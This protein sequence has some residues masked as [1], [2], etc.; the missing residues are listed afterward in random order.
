MTWFNNRKLL[1]ASQHQ[2][3]KAIAPLMEQAFSLF[4]E[5]PRQFDSDVFGT[6]SG[7]VERKFNPLET[8]RMKGREAASLNKVD[9]VISSEGSFGPHPQLYFLPFNQELLLLQD[10]KNGFEIHVNESSTQTNY[11]AESISGVP[12][13][14]QFA[15]RIGFPE[16]GI[17]LKDRAENFNLCIKG[18]Q[19]AAKLTENYERLVEQFGSVHAET[20]MRAHLNPTRMQV[21]TKACEK[22]VQRMQQCCEQC[23][24]PGFGEL[25]YTPGLACSWCGMPTAL[26]LKKELVCP[27]CAFTKEISYEKDSGA[28]PMHCLQCNP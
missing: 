6:F 18:I 23:N 4:C 25:T 24:L 13:L 20:D 11:A 7:E 28:D 16:H 1:I 21:I 10:L 26:P 5:I 9:L 3:E 17:I 27:H 19:D 15:K 14:L 2:K 22:L 8:A 12:A